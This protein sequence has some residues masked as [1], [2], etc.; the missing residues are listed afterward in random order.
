MAAQQHR[1]DAI[2]HVLQRGQLVAGH[3]GTYTPA[4]DKDTPLPDERQRVQVNAAEALTEFA[5][6]LTPAW[7]IA[8]TRDWANC[9]AKADV[10]VDGTVLLSQ[11]P[12]TYLLWLETQLSHLRTVIL[13]A[14]VL[15]AAEDWQEDDTTAGLHRTAPVDTVRTKKITDQVVVIQPT[16]KYPGQW[17]EVSKDVP[18]GTWTRTKFS[19]AL[20][21]D[22]QKLLAGRVEKLRDAVKEA[23][24]EANSADVPDVKTGET[25]FGW[26]FAG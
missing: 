2:Y 10:M 3:A 11:V 25:L 17:T 16:D 19:G 13:S 23:R 14:P 8:A 7:D 26:L 5:Q 1:A 24:N 21:A 22:R 4:S 6:V 20:T 18:A 9:T 15:D 12:V